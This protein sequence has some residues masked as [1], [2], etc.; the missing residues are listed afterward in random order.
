MVILLNLVIPILL[1][2]GILVSYKL[3]KGWPVLLSAV[4]CITY[5][6]VQPSYVPKGKIIRSDIPAFEYKETKVEDR[7]I[8]PET[9]EVY[10]AKRNTSVKEGLPF[11]EVIDNE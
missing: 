8:K 2:V 11:K 7:L 5:T 4:L 9:G 1:L 6:M 3:K 10:D